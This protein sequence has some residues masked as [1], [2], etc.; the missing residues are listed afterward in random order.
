MNGSMWI[1][2]VAKESRNS[3]SLTE[4]SIKSCHRI[5]SIQTALFDSLLEIKTLRSLA[6]KLSLLDSPLNADGA[7]K[8][9]S[10]LE[11]NR[12]TS[13][14]FDLNRERFRFLLFY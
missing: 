11:T 8:L 12:L 4:L 5:M 1:E 14:K 9:I 13:F 7:P 2:L 10:L 6:I 3:T